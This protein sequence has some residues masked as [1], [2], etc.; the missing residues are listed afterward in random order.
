MSIPA[1]E[2]GKA[3]NTAVSALI[4]ATPCQMLGF[5]VN[6]QAGTGTLVIR[7]GG[8]SGTAGSAVISGTITPAIGYHKFP[9]DIKNGGLHVTIAV[10]ALDIT[11]FYV[12]TGY[13]V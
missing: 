11:V 4:T 5:Y 12:S 8:A 7:S 2:A 1:V 3:V 6:S 10:A 13:S 9:A